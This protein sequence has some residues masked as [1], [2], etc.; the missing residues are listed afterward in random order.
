[1]KKDAEVLIDIMK[2]EDLTEVMAIEKQS[3]V[4]PWTWG[5]FEKEIN[6][7]QSQ[8][9][10]ARVNNGK[11]H[12]IC[13][14]II[15]WLVADEAHLHNLA[16]LPELRGQGLAGYLLSAMKEISKQLGIKAQTLEVRENN[17]EAIKLYGKYGFVVKGRRRNYYSDT[18]EDALIMWA[19]V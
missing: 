3:F 9:L 6:A 15:F 1:M 4:S 16:V 12:F 18:N 2:Q 7:G 5:M 17:K 19:D 11:N 14:Y 8:C 10:V 13:G